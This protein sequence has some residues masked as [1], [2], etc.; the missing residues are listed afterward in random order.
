MVEKHWFWATLTL[1]SI[2]I[3]SVVFAAWE[4]VENRYFRNADYLTLHYLYITRGVASSLLL[5]F[6]AAW[7]VLRQ[8]RKSEEDL[9]RSRERYRGLLQAFPG[10]VIL[11]DSALQVLEWNASAERMYGYKNDEI[12]GQPLPI[13]PP[14]K[15]SELREFIGRVKE[16]Q[17]VFDAETM[18]LARNGEP[19]EVQLSLL[20]FRE[21]PAHM[22]FVE[23]TS[24]IRERVRWRERMLEVE[25]LTSMGKMAAGTAHHLNS[26]LAALLLRVQMMRERA[27]D[28]SADDIARLEDGL[29]FCKH[30]V[31][32]LLEFT[33]PTAVEKR[34]QDLGATI[35]S[36]AGFILPTIQAKHVTLSLETAQAKG[37][38][39]Y[40]DRNLLEALLLILLTNALDAVAPGG[41]IRIRCT[42]ADSGRIAFAVSDNGCGIGARDLEHIFEPFFTT[43]D[44]GKGTGLGLAIAKNVVLEHGGAIRMESEPGAGATAW[45]ELPVAKPAAQEPAM[46]KE[47]V[48]L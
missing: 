25:K 17:P 26:P 46:Q 34:N 2:T 13:I 38:Q 20:P 24:D 47:K 15:M 19:F 7:F 4:L 32:R 45:V 23:V 18:R 31:Q 30:F 12:C 40:A 8:K 10:A 33:R 48:A 28:L 1:S 37:K 11:Y 9:R 6:W 44:P 42:A 21:S 14:D 5:A 39:V 43:K 3:V 41:Q 22:Y 27:A 35:E 29:K 36:V 16:G